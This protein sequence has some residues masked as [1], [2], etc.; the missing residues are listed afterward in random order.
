MPLFP[1]FVPSVLFVLSVLFPG[2]SQAETLD[3]GRAIYMQRCFWCHGETGH[4]D[5]PSAVGMF[6]RPRD[7][8]AADY[9]IR[10][11]PHGH[12]PTDEDLLRVISRGIPGTPMPAWVKIL[13]QEEHHAL[14]A[15]LKSLSP[16][17][18]AEKP[19]PL[20]V[21]DGPANPEA[22]KE[23]YRKARCFLCH[24]EAGRGDGE[25]TAT[26]NFEWGIPHS[27]RD[28]TRGWTF[29]GGHEPHDI[30]LRIT[31]GLN[32]TPMGPYA[33]ILT[34]Q[35]RWDLAH[36]VASLDLEPSAT[37]E[38]FLVTAALIEGNLPETHDG[39]AWQKARMLT[40]PLAGQ[41][42]QSPPLRW[43][44][45]SAGACNVRALHNGHDIAFL[46]EWDDPTGKPEPL[47]DSAFLQFPAQEGSKPY[48]LFGDSDNPVKLW[49][50]QAGNTAEEWTATGSANTE[51]RPAI[52]QVYPSYKEGRW[53][54][55]FRRSLSGE[56]SFEAGKFLP[57]LFSVR[58]GA[59]GESGNVRAT[60][61]WLYVTVE[62]PRSFRP[63]L[64]ALA[65]MLGAGVVE[66]WVLAKL[67]S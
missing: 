29:K 44:T 31:G 13:S 5:G 12:L 2:P 45:P 21:P 7:F 24:G 14:V 39:P 59:N 23:V 66:L 26:L 57:V 48:F 52:F 56:P 49:H 51:V 3:L 65:Y 62:R 22:G 8:V 50:W 35:E 40:V 19:Q 58:D 63:W 55:L 30:Y 9:K 47:P 60:S 36:Y 43:W 42:V 1:L 15:Y 64:L 27:A 34:D 41:I 54:V 53:R 16:R 11:T 18:A 61:T 20:P 33:D 4:G 17:F 46:V 25:L 10:S 6:P 37:T 67:K 38:D 32:G 28:F